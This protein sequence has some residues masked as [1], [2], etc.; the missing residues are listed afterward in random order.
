M[1]L[2]PYIIIAVMGGGT[3]LAAVS[4]G[5]VP[6][7]LGGAI[8]S[9]VVMS[10]VFLGG[11]RG[12]AWVNAFQTIAVPAVRR[13]RGRR[14]SAAAWA[15]SAARW[16]RCWRRRRRR[17]CSRRERVSPLYFFSYTFIPLSSITFPHIGIFCLTARRLGHFKKTVILY[18]VCMLL[19][20][21]PSVFL[22]VAANAAPG[23]AGDRGEARRAEHARQCRA[24]PVARRARPAPRRGRP[25]TTSFCGSSMATRRCGWPRCS[26]PR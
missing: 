17:R 23:R 1:L 21:L 7:W 6:Y 3:T 4:G 16:S 2:V 25:A 5:L 18:P 22:G 20:W 13:D 14:S 24:D 19:I 9:L 8:V 12:T 10:Y 11:M 15:V 26:G